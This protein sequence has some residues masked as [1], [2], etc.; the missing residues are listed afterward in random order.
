[1]K[2]ENQNKPDKGREKP[3]DRLQKL[4]CD[5][6]G[7]DYDIWSDEYIL[8]LQSDLASLR[9]ELSTEK[10]FRLEDA[11]SANE[12]YTVMWQKFQDEVTSLRSEIERLK[13]E[14]DEAI[15]KMYCRCPFPSRI[16]FN[17]VTFC[18]NCNKH[19]A[20]ALEPAQNE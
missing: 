16:T 10:R 2:M 12:H 6:C 14:R 4:H 5:D 1:M 20:P 15:K 8:S 3:I 9:S 13:W 18:W 7:Q 17:N 11:A 19:L